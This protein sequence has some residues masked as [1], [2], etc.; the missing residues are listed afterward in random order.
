MYPLCDSIAFVRTVQIGDRQCSVLGFGCGAVV[1]RV[2]RRQSLRAMEIA[3][4][5]GINFFDTARSYGYGEAEGVL[6]GFLAG[7]REQAIVSTKFGI[8]PH[9]PST[10]KRLAKPPVR[11]LLKV[12]PQ[13]RGLVRRA[14]TTPSA[15]GHFSVAELRSSLEESLRQLRTDY[16]DFLFLHEAPASALAMD[17]LMAE[18]E[19]LRTAGKLR[20]VGTSSDAALTQQFMVEGVPPPLT[21]LQFAANI[22]DLGATTVSQHA[23]ARG[24]FLVANHPFG[25]A[26]GIEKTRERLTALASD[27]AL[28]SGLRAKLREIPLHT[29]LPEVLFGVVLRGTGI[30][31]LVPSMLHEENL[32]ANIAAIDS[33]R[34]TE[35][36]IATLRKHLLTP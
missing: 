35:E 12:V 13:A 7:R 31:T 28:E 4:D 8:Q 16:V 18:L 19:D 10:L 21:A 20:C 14:A 30:H 22:F 32:R 33:T 29:L 36:E 11:A 17:D 9:A 26:N 27:E 23:A 6:G 15:G 2:G 34:F 3:W 25:G 1:G 5:A 24:I